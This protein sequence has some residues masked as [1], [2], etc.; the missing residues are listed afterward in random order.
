MPQPIVRRIEFTKM[1]GAGNDF[2]V[3][4]NRQGIVQDPDRFAVVLCDRRKGIG[5]DGLLL[6]ENSPTADFGMKYYNADGTYG[7]MCGN[8]GRCISRFA[9]HKRI[10][11]TSELKFEA[12]NYVYGAS[13]GS[14]EV[15]L[16]MKPPTRLTLRKQIEISV[17]RLLVHFIDTGSPHCVIFL[18]EN[19]S[20]G[21]L[22]DLNVTLLGKEIRNNKAFLPEGTNANFLEMLP[23]N[24]IT[25]RTY[26]R[27]VEAETLACGTG[28]VASAIVAAE[29]KSVVAPVSVGVHSGEKLIVNFKKTSEG[30]YSDISLTGSAR[31]AFEGIVSYNFS[32]H[33]IID[34]EE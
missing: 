11:T 10:V 29:V 3:V 14:S 20:L 13:I 32:S 26:E 12:L 17:G 16:R 30:L 9:Y 22:S 8:G 33:S 15:E 18:D 21:Y 27:G 28:S 4:D 6:L 25:I 34:V 7:G 19:K 23:S 5:A 2:V 1:S 24:K 31:I